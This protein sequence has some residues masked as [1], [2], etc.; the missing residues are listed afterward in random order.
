VVKYLGVKFDNLLSFFPQVEHAKTRVL[1]VRGQLNSLVCRRSK[2]STK[3]KV[4]I[5]RQIVRPA[6][7]Y[8][9][10]M[11]G[12]VSNTQ[13]EK[14]QVVQNKF[15]RAAF[16]AP[17]FV[18]NSQL[19]RE[20]N[21]PTIR[22]SSCTMLLGNS[23]RVRLNTQTPLY[24]MP[25]I[26]TRTCHSDSGTNDRSVCSSERTEVQLP[27]VRCFCFRPPQICVVSSKQIIN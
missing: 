21:L 15:L 10:A 5:Y 6:M 20:V 7:M 25:S 4:T 13:L 22:E 16:S 3:N 26:M 1:I 23:L 18:R 27:L 19:H 17:W 12:N 11:W 8:G 14:L 9:S 2:M 24:P